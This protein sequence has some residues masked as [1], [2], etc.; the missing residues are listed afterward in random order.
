MDQAEEH[1]L[2]STQAHGLDRQRH[3][4]PRLQVR[5]VQARAGKTVKIHSGK[6]SN[7]ARDRFWRSDGYIWNND[8]DRA[9]LKSKAG[10]VIDTCSY[11][12]A[13]SSV[14]C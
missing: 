14:S 6:G 11:S 2:N 1:W 13:G 12:G 10:T 8:G 3:E 5:D 9:K 4:W 7:T